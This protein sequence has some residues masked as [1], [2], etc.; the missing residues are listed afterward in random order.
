MSK[1]YMLALYNNFDE[2]EKVVKEL[3]SADIKGFDAD[4]D[5]T[6]KSPIEHPEVEEFLA[7]WGGFDATRHPLARPI[8]IGVR[9][10]TAPAPER[11]YLEDVQ[12]LLP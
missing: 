2:A 7:R 4:D 10:I 9:A 12:P 1:R 3:R 8:G 5:L 6:V 11:A